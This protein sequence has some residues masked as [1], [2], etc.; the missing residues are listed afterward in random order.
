VKVSVD[1]FSQI[2]YTQINNPQGGC[3]GISW[4]SG[5]KLTNKNMGAALDCGQKW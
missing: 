3:I 2:L 4:F 1:Q 5:K